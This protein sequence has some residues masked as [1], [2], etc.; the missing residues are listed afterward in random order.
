MF[1]KFFISIAILA[2]VIM[3]IL[4]IVDSEDYRSKSYAK[5]IGWSALVGIFSMAFALIAY[6]WS[7]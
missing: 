5:Q 1:V 3:A 7:Y 4:L 2:F 6:V